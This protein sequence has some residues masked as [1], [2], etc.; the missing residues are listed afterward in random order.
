LPAS[1]VVA[2]VSLS[3]AALGHP[4]W[5]STIA[6]VTNQ[7]KARWMIIDEV[8][9]ADKLIEFKQALITDARKKVFLILNKLRVHHTKPVKA[10]CSG[11][12]ATALNSP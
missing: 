4:P 1:A 8:F 3:V 6:A 5:L 12:P 7:G 2:S 10:R 11:C 9:N